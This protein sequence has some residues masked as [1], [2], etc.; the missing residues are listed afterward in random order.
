MILAI[1]PA[2]GGSKR[3]PRK[4]LVELCGKPLIQYTIEAAS[5][6]ALLDKIVV[7]S[8][9]E[10]ILSICAKLGVNSSYR[11][12]RWL[13]CDKTPMALSV[14]HCLSWAE[15][16]FGPIESFIL[17]QPTSPLR[18]TFDIDSAMESYI[19]RKANSLVSVT[20]MI[21][22]PLECLRWHGGS[23]WSYLVGSD[24]PT[25]SSQDYEKCFYFINGAIYISNVNHFLR[26]SKFFD[27]RNV[28]FHEMPRERSLD[29]DEPI[30]LLFAEVLIARLKV[31]TTEGV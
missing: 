17:L 23:D 9:D 12:P 21:E 27:Q 14:K 4:N 5:R 1:I 11:R 30:D 10:E 13:A 6:S 24:E 28:I 25:S 19:S 22:H 2:R 18:S 31:S 20:P 15:N 7:S 16:E 3:I 29:V 8:E 26:T